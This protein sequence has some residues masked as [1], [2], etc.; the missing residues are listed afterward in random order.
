MKTAIV[1]GVTGQDGSYLTDL[2]IS[3]N[4][5]VV[6]VARRSSVDTTERIGEH[7]KNENF[8]LV[9]ETLPMDFV[10]LTLLISMSQMKFTI[11]L[12]SLTLGH[13]LNNRH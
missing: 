13:L 1:F 11:L 12:L 5:K 10:S 3:K 6:G 4:Y 9:E 8:V 2:L 7:Q